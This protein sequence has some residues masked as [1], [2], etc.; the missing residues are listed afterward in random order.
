[1]I[2]S[3]P[4][5]PLEEHLK[6]VAEQSYEYVISKKLNTKVFTHKQI[7][8]TAY[9][10]GI[11][12]DFGKF[13][14]YFQS[15]LSKGYNDNPTHH[16][17]ISSLLAYKAIK[18]QFPES[19]YLPLMGYMGVRYHHGNLRTP[20][21]EF[22]KVKDVQDQWED[23]KGHHYQE[24]KDSYKR[25]LPKHFETL[26][27]FNQ[28]DQWIG[29]KNNIKDLPKSFYKTIL[30]EVKRQ[31]LSDED[32]IEIFVTNNLLFSL[33][34]DS[35]KKN[36]GSLDINY[37]KGSENINLNVEGY[38]KFL[39]AEK[40]E[41]FNPHKSVNQKRDQFFNECLHS[42]SL[43]KGK[44]YNL[45]AP[46]GIGKTFSAMGAV[47]KIERT[48][49]EQRKLVYCLPFTSII[50]Q[51]FNEL[52]SLLKWQLKEEFEN[53]PTRYLL[54]HHHLAS[55]SIEREN[56]DV[57]KDYAQY[58][59]DA[60]LNESWDSGNIVTT[61][62]QFFQSI[63]GHRNRNLKK[64]HNII[65]SIILLDEVQNIPG[66]YHEITGK[67]LNVIANRFD[68]PVILMTATQ[69]N[70]LPKENTQEIVKPEKYFAISELNRVQVSA[71]NNLESLG[72][73]EFGGFLKQTKVPDQ[74]LFVCNTKRAAFNLFSL[75]KGL[76][77]KNQKVYCLTTLL[78]PKD[79]KNIINEVKERT[80][81]GEKV[82]CVSTQ[83]IEAGVNLSFPIVYRDLGPFDSIVQVAGRCNRNGEIEKGEMYVVQLKDEY[84]KPFSSYV[85]DPKI[86]QFTSEVLNIYQTFESKDFYH[87]GKEYFKKFD[88][89]RDSKALMEGIKKLNYDKEIDDE[90]P[91]SHFDLIKNMPNQED[92][93][94][95]QNQEIEDDIN[96]LINLRSKI[97]NEDLSDK[98]KKSQMGKALEINRNFASYKITLSDK[99]LEGHRNSP[100]IV[101]FF[102]GKAENEMLYIPHSSYNKGNIYSSL[103]GFN[104]FGNTENQSFSF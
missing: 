52:E 33:L 47:S 55:K 10:L 76:A 11:T 64:F 18:Y 7:R 42:E 82:L 79:R 62:V 16:A 65:N 61:F 3:H 12:H 88:F 96:E 20:D 92:V 24:V 59:D 25:L 49:A 71:F 4:G 97:K 56:E 68:T 72:I 13:T 73:E 37:F 22:E 29:D 98:E 46:T 66:K 77:S 14:T 103:I 104:A 67:L 53:T 41:D 26:N 32:F 50:D 40:P 9:L 38:L 81:R 17:P 70:I 60:L 35:D 84:E 101:D 34:I 31:N 8:T 45:T 28:F 54:K 43:K 87:L 95:C 2:Q 86:I 23:I 78:T 19:F 51:N 39:K 90:L 44:L 93:I 57:S 58:F 100:D 102:N 89:R 75:L 1:M 80:E 30:K 91:V 74:A 94:V 5:K 69:P 48:K 99:D 21:S 63:L 36:A 6:E 83:L 27:F 85:Y 15:M